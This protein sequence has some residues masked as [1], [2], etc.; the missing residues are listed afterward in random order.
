MDEAN[1]RVYLKVLIEALEKKREVLDRLKVQTLRQ[2]T[3]LKSETFDEKGFDDAMS[4]KDSLLREL[5]KLDDGFDNVF[6]HVSGMLSESRYEYREEIL[7]LQELIGQITQV[8]VELRSLEEQNRSCL[9]LVLSTGRKK[10]KDFKVSSKTAAAYYRNMSNQHQAE[11][12][13]F[14]D[15]RE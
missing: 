9:Q 6:A 10:I 12:S 15:K 7:R 14:V 4:K 3:L 13:Y 1:S 2:H 5:A 11:D 8:G